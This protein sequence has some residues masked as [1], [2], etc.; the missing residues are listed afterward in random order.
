MT[1][2]KYANENGLYSIST[3]KNLKSYQRIS[4]CFFSF[5]LPE[6]ATL[7]YKTKNVMQTNEL[8]RF[9]HLQMQLERSVSAIKFVKAKDLHSVTFQWIKLHQENNK[10]DT[11]IYN[12]INLSKIIDL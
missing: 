7:L 11:K 3:L 9:V 10:R 2:W 4:R 8:S 1:F 5:L 6:L 12:E